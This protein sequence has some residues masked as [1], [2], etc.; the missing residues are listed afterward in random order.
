[1][2]VISESML[3][4]EIV[5]QKVLSDGALK[6]VSLTFLLGPCPAN[7]VLAYCKENIALVPIKEAVSYLHGRDVVV[8]NIYKRYF[9]S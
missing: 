1:M 3:L 9:Y 2:D 6:E 4:I 5:V 8:D 7:L